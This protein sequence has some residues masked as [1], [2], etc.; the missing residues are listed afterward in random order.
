M[1]RKDQSELITAI[2]VLKDF[3]EKS[4]AKEPRKMSL[5]L[6]WKK[7]F[8]KKGNFGIYCLV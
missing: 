1:D 7:I 5:F 2:D 4:Q 6:P 3:V 8:C